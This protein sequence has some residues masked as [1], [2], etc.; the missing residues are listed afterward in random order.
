MLFP[1]PPCSY[2]FRF[3]PHLQV[4]HWT[5]DRKTQRVK[6]KVE[7]K[8]RNE[9]H[10]RENI[11]FKSSL[12]QWFVENSYQAVQSSS[13]QVHCTQLHAT[14]VWWWSCGGRWCQIQIKE[15][16][17]QVSLGRDDSSDFI[18]CTSR[19][20]IRALTLCTI[21]DFK[22]GNKKWHLVLLLTFFRTLLML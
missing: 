9:R 14:R 21:K 20:G 4:Q 6:G 8:K 3:I 16:S 2:R 10:Q 22:K 12:Q 13:Q 18:C 17:Q 19:N 7:E 11:K 5:E 15:I 1:F